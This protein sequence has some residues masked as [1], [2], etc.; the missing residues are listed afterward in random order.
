[1]STQGFYKYSDGLLYAPTR[2]HT[3]AYSLTADTRDQL[4]LPIDG[5]NWYEN[6]AAAEA[7]LLIV[8]T[9]PPTAITEY[10]FRRRFTPTER[11]SIEIA[12]LDDPAAPIEQRMAAATLRASQAD[13][14]SAK[15]IDF[16]DPATIDGL[17]DLEQF[18]LIAEGRAAVILT[19]PV[20][21]SERP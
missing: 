8:P 19:T 11:A 21:D 14:R 3:A 20:Q 10:A 6:Q 5:W 17:N 15:W 7:A 4:A 12:S 2:V 1:M 18:G 16:A 13:A 9:A